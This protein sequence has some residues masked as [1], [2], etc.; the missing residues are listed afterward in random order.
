MMLQRLISYSIPFFFYPAGNPSLSIPTVSQH[1]IV[2]S[3][4]YLSQLQNETYLPRPRGLRA[5][6]NLL[7]FYQFTG[8][9]LFDL[10]LLSC[11][12]RVIQAITFP[13]SAIITVSSVFR[14][15]TSVQKSPIRVHGGA[16]PAELFLSITFPPAPF[17]SKP[18]LP[19]QIL[20][21]VPQPCLPLPSFAPPSSGFPLY[22]SAR[23]AKLGGMCLFD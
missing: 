23:W 9:V 10:S 2:Q 3:S 4:C 11:K 22:F 6:S 18:W 20:S 16:Q 13:S 5:M 12:Y 1:P 8:T 21:Q 15:W 7:E 17:F 19:F 14:S